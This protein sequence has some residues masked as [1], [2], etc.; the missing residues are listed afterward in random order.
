MHARGA[1]AADKGSTFA[2]ALLVDVQAAL[3]LLS[4]KRLPHQ[5]HTSHG[6]LRTQLLEHLLLL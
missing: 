4:W 5:Q 2:E 6:C 1:V 3:H